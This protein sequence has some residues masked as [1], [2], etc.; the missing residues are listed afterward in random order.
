MY[1]NEKDVGSGWENVTLGPSEGINI[2]SLSKDSHVVCFERLARGSK[3]GLG[4][5]TKMKL[6]HQSSFD[7]LQRTHWKAYGYLIER[8]D[9]S[10]K[11]CSPT[12]ICLE[13]ISFIKALRNTLMKGELLS[14][15]IS[16]VAVRCGSRMTVRSAAIKTGI[17][18]FS[19]DH[20][21]SRLQWPSG[22]T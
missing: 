17:S 12:Y 10:C 9:L 13:Y 6:S 21:V 5:L 1:E 14:L 15:K 19:K 7:K 22:R 18:E 8:L 11:T 16:V 20:G 3:F 2:C 4:W